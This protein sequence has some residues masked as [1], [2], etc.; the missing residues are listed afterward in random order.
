M[1]AA[2][3]DLGSL[4]QALACHLSALEIAESL[5]DKAG[6]AHVLLD[7][8]RD[9]VARGDVEHARQAF[10]RSAREARSRRLA[11]DLVAT[12]TDL[13]ALRLRSGD[14]RG[15]LKDASEALRETEQVS[16]PGPPRWPWR[17][18]WCACPAF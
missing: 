5:S 3:R 2:H 13:A 6:T 10:E 11:S 7:I 12:L 8:G 17:W 15:A 9:Y 16:A 1:G 14:S 4:D 18:S